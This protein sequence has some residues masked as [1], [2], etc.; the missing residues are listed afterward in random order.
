MAHFIG[1][2]EKTGEKSASGMASL[3]MQEKPKEIGC[4]ETG[5]NA[6]EGSKDATKDER[7]DMGI[8]T[9]TV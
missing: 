8:V 9:K 7:R 3:A 4:T 6:E 5:K 1:V 2:N